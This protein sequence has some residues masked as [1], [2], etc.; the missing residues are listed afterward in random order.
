MRN[1]V[2]Y[3]LSTFQNHI[4]EHVRAA[5]W[6]KIGRMDYL[7]RETVRVGK[8]EY[9][10]VPE[11]GA[12]IDIFVRNRKGLR[13]TLFV[14]YYVKYGAVRLRRYVQTN[15]D[16]ASSFWLEGPCENPL[17]TPGIEEIE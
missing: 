15:T 6:F 12:L 8:G 9:E 17:I 1:N 10:S 13:Y 4:Q 2:E 5:G 7:N 16:E 3:E 14:Y 11:D